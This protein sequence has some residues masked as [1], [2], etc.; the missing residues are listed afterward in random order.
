MF[1][2]ARGWRSSTAAWEGGRRLAR[3]TGSFCF[4][5]KSG[6]GFCALSTPFSLAWNRDSRPLSTSPCSPR[7]PPAIAEKGTPPPDG[8]PACS[9]CWD[10]WAVHL[11]SRIFA[12]IS[13]STTPVCRLYLR[14][15]VLPASLLCFNSVLATLIPP[16]LCLFC[17]LSA[18]SFYFSRARRDVAPPSPPAPCN[19]Q[20][21]SKSRVNGDERTFAV[22][23]PMWFRFITRMAVVTVNILD[24]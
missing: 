9:V 14:V 10:T 12:H 1:K 2:S 5:A 7:H 4:A 21:P 15:P 8:T 11:R 16:D 18:F 22:R 24:L 13:T 3:A 20:R 23:L 19:E 17:S 6:G